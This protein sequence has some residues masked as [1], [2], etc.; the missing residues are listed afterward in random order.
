MTRI[1]AFI[2]LLGCIITIGCKKTGPEGPAGPAGAAGPAGPAGPTGP[3]GTANVIYSRWTNGSTW[4]VDGGTGLNTFNISAATLTQGIL[5]GGSI[6]VYWAVLGDTVNHVRELPFAE[7]LGANIFFH[8]PKYSVGNI[9]IETNNLTMAATNRY[10][11]ILIP[12]GVL[13][14]RY[15]EINFSDYQEVIRKLKIPY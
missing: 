6:H 14:G 7:T 10:R 5:S 15:T 11:Y 2:I 8:N 3:A 9:R 4:T 1:S 12:G 13:S